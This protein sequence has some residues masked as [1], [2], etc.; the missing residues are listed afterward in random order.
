MS[1]IGKKAIAIPD[2]VK[3]TVAGSRVKVEGPN[4]KLEKEIVQGITVEQNGKEI[5]LKRDSESIQSRANH[6]LMRALIQNMVTG[7]SSGFTRRLEIRGVGFRAE[8]KG[9]A[10]TF[11]L[12]YSHQIDFKLP[13]D[14][15]VEIDAKTN[16]ISL[17][18]FDKELL[19]SVAANIRSLRP[20]EPYGQ[21]GIRYE[22]E[23][24]KAKVGK[25][26]AK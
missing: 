7:V 25:T 15:K 26:G 16:K 11:N 12:G 18:S 6:G 17:T 22:G 14:V 1:R 23:H 3:I 13:K 10:I 21:T 4:G 8:P 5:N 24:V 2:K 9:Q 19:G 20:P